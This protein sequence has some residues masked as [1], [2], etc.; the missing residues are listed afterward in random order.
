MKSLLKDIDE[1]ENE[2]LKIKEESVKQEDIKT[3][4]KAKDDKSERRRE[5]S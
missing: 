2:V 5:D 4:K 1:I 3:E